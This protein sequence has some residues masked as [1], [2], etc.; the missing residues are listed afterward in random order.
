MNS[1]VYLTKKKSKIGKEISKS[2]WAIFKIK[3]NRKVRLL[4]QCFTKPSVVFN[5]INGTKL[6]ERGHIKN[7]VWH[8]SNAV[9]GESLYIKRIDNYCHQSAWLAI[10]EMLERKQ[11][12]KWYCISCQKTIS[13]GDETIA[14]NILH[15]ISA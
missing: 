8:S 14:W 6:I 9:R 3:T 2:C 13:K 12:C 11:K 4:L 7:N 5:T 15:G 1:L 10:F